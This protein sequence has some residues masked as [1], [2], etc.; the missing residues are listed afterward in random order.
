MDSVRKPRGSLEIRTLAMPKDTNPN[1]DIFGGWVLS[2][3]DIAGGTAAFAR[4]GGRVATVAV[5]SMTF[6][7]PVSVGDVLNCYA[8]VIRVGRSSLAVRIEAWSERRHTG[9]MLLVTEGTFTF[10]AIGE[11]RRP[12]PVDPPATA[13]V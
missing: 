6:H 8:E 1:G 13:T 4:A 3:M 12:R 9:E 2:Q 11:D 5:D 10:V 7:R